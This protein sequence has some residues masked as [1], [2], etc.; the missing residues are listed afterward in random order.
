MHPELFRI[1]PFVIH[2]YGVLIA[3]GIFVSV[4]TATKLAKKTS[5]PPSEKVFDLFFV[6][7]A[8]G[9]A[10]ARIFYVLQEG[11][12]YQ[13]HPLE[14]F[15]IW[16]GGLV[17]YGGVMGASVGYFFYTR[18]QGFP[19]LKSIDFTLP[20]IALTHAFGRVGCFFAGCCFGKNGQPVQLY[21]ALFNLILAGFLVKVYQKS[22]FGGQVF[23]HYLILYPMARFFFEFLRADQPVWL[24]SLTLQQFVSLVFIFLGLGLYG[25]HRSRN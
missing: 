1:G 8:S 10:G 7:V 15:K 24:F 6:A 23:A 2:T 3:L 20:F 13:S 22:K 17:Y 19:Y 21:E 9:F 4:I 16:E 5:F 12:Y 18:R 11:G 14:I 25:I